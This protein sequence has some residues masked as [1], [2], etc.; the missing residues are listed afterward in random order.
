MSLKRKAFTEPGARE[1]DAAAAA[2]TDVKMAYQAD[3]GTKLKVTSS[4]NPL[5]QKKNAMDLA[6]SQYESAK[7]EYQMAVSETA[8]K[9]AAKYEDHTKAFLFALAKELN[10]LARMKDE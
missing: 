8:K 7:F 1:S 6:Q 10:D 3:P 4:S 2:D 9:E 5:A